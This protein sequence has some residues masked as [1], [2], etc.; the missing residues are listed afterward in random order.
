MTQS[1]KTQSVKVT[2]RIMRLHRFWESQLA[3]ADALWLAFRSVD[4]PAFEGSRPTRQARLLWLMQ[5]GMAKP[6]QGP[7]RVPTRPLDRLR[8]VSMWIPAKA[9]AALNRGLDGYAALLRAANG[10]IGQPSRAEAARFAL[11]A[12]LREAQALA[13]QLMATPAQQA[14]AA[15]GRRDKVTSSW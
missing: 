8:K 2:R 4:Y 13:R 3:W 12:G 7:C 15:R 10:W 14:P 1:V 5:L 9:S 6:P 11:H